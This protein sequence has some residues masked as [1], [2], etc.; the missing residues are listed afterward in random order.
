MKGT[1]NA[2]AAAGA[3][4]T[5][6]VA[7]DCPSAPTWQP[8]V[9]ASRTAAAHVGKR[10][11]R[12]SDPAELEKFLI[13]FVV[14]QTGYPPEVVELDADLEADLGIDSIKKA[15]LFGELAEYFD[16]Q[17]TENL[18]LDDFPTL[19]HVLNFLAG[20]PMKG[21]SHAAAPGCRASSVAAA[22]AAPT[23][24]PPVELPPAM[25]ASQRRR[26]TARSH[27]GPTQPRPGRAGKVP[28]QLR[29]R[30]DRLSAG[31]R[32]AGRR[33]GSRP[34]HRQHQEGAALRRAG[35]VLRRAAEREHDARRFPD[36]ASRA[37]LP[38]WQR[39]K[40]KLNT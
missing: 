17:P 6:P 24:Q 18:T 26:R 3:S 8:T 39:L 21:A 36:A 4:S 16:V 12:V 15:Q 32:R 28:D 38:G 11:G 7:A 29:G 1:A 40:K 33:P 23:W 37:E 34:G 2:G 13:N 25:A 31:S 19:R 35:R 27:G 20:A 5:A 9:A 14:E 30:A 22:P 10:L